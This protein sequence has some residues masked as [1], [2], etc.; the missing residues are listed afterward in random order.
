MTKR[1]TY[2]DYNA[3]APL[4]EAART[5]MLAAMDDGFANPS[6]VHQAGREA[7]RIVEAARAQVVDLCGGCAGRVVFTSGGTEANSLALLGG[8]K[9]NGIERLVISGVEHPSV[10]QAA[11]AAGLPVDVI[12]TLPNGLVDLGRLQKLLNNG[13]ALVSVMAV[14]NELGTIQPI[15]QIAALV[16]E[17]GSLLHVDAVQAA[18][19]EP[20]GAITALADFVSLSAHKIGGPKGVG[21]LHIKAG[22]EIA[23]ILVGGGQ[24]L[25]SRA[26][27]ENVYAIAGFG[28]AAVEA[29]VRL[30]QQASIA[31]LRDRMEQA[32]SVEGGVIVGKDAPRVAN[33][34][35]IQMRGVSAETQVMALDLEGFM[36]SAGS[37]C[38]SGKV[39]ASAALLNMGFSEDEA[40][41]VIRVSLGPDTTEQEIEGFI[42]AWTNLNARLARCAA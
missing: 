34:S 1:V 36:V 11:H 17:A 25:G 35:A 29:V 12:A 39:G 37:A 23:P 32:I 38:S 8:A 13:R 10:A 41:S 6:S 5:A 4:S 19:R 22:R 20:L 31:A 16:E 21:A 30:E 42:K 18:G 15:E 24:E 14:Q 3:T 26:G 2:L 9:A 33:T 28:A 7:K 27:T 40:K